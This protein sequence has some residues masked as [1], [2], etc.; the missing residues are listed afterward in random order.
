MLVPQGFASV[1]AE[2]PAWLFL[3]SV[4]RKG[5]GPLLVPQGFAFVLAELSPERASLLLDAVLITDCLKYSGLSKAL[6]SAS[7]VPIPSVPMHIPG[8]LFVLALSVGHLGWSRLCVCFIALS[9][10][11]P[12]PS[13]AFSL[14]V[15]SREVPCPAWH[16]LSP[17]GWQCP[18]SSFDPRPASSMAVAVL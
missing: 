17:R 4:Q 1:L 16:V 8:Y 6:T 15:H 18:A 7:L 3:S 12:A 2:L 13:T 9:S 5:R 14:G 10:Q 11:E